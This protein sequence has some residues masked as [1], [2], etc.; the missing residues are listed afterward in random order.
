MNIQSD[1]IIPQDRAEHF[2]KWFLLY[3]EMNLMKSYAIQSFKDGYLS[4]AFKFY[5]AYRKIKKVL[6]NTGSVLCELSEQK[7]EMIRQWK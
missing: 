4:Q 7:L 1:I 3:D 2:R 5:K 6:A